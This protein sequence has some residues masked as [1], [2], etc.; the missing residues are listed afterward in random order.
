MTMVCILSPAPIWVNPRLCKEADT[1]QRAG[2]D[3]VVGYRA[4]GDIS[5]DDA[6]LGGRSWRW[7]RIDLDRRRAPARWLE[8][9]LRQ[10][11]AVWMWRSGNRSPSV[12]R[13][14][15]CAGDARLLRWALEQPADVYIAHTQPVLAIAA[16]AAA[17]RGVVYAFDCEDLLAEETADG[18]R[19][20]WR[21]DLITGLE[22]RYLPAAT[23]VSATS[24]PMAAHLAAAYGL[25]TVRVW[26]NCFPASESATVPPPEQRPPAT[27][28]ELAWISATVGPARGLEDAFAAM[29]RLASRAVLHIYGAV[30]ADSTRWLD[31][32]MTAI[33][34]RTRVE[35]HPLVPADQVIP[36]LS[37]HHVGLSLDGNE[38]L[39]RSL[40]VSNKVFYYLQAGLACVATDTP[41][42]RS[43]I[44]PGSPYGFLYPPRDVSS[45]VATLEGLT[46]PP[47][48]AAAQRAAW[49]VGRT[50]YVWDLEQ[51]R[52]VE[53]IRGAARARRPLL[54]ASEAERV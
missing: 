19:A 30:P 29:P 41:G 2:F 6:V 37:R 36:T 28:L 42:H 12:A 50:K 46:S 24:D 38:C 35:M 32:Q 43:V 18:G 31:A 5:R 34:D 17:A 23:Y 14:A 10:R 4:D 40:T 33:G 3:V 27:T 11:A 15:Y 39:N 16:L 45:L 53:A 13:A 47:N 25:Q 20:R 52:V 8:S 26:H 54:R 21:R 48:L 44:P 9:R 49:K 22:R 51:T 7:A 1:L